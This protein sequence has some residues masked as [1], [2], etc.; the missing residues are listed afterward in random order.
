MENSV[1][2][3]IPQETHPPRLVAKSDIEIEK[4][5]AALSV[6]GTPR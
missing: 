4:R 1:S 6:A 5:S 2:S 3:N